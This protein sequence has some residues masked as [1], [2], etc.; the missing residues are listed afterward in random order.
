MA[1][2]ANSWPQADFLRWNRNVFRRVSKQSN[3]ASA[4]GNTV[5]GNAARINNSSAPD[6]T[7]VGYV[8]QGANNYVQFNHVHAA[9]AGL[10]RMLVTYANG[11]IYSGNKRGP[12]FR[13]AEISVN[14]GEGKSVYFNNTFSSTTWSTQEVDVYLS[15]VKTRFVFPTVQPVRIQRSIRDGLR[16]WQRYRSRQPTIEMQFHAQHHVS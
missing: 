8:G 11:E 13:F 9:A 15:A 2:Q 10:Y 14:G 3:E 16:N 7:D 1:V 5:S 12:V 6:G 4:T